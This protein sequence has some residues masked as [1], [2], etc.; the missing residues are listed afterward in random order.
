MKCKIL[1]CSTLIGA[2]VLLATEGENVLED[3]N[4][5]EEVS[6]PDTLKIIE[7]SVVNNNETSIINNSEAS[8]NQWEEGVKKNTEGFTIIKAE[9]I[10]FMLGVAK[11]QDPW[12]LGLRHCAALQNWLLE[13]RINNSTY[14]TFPL[15]IDL[16]LTNKKLAK[17]AILVKEGNRFRVA[18]TPKQLQEFL[19]NNV[20]TN[21]EIRSE[22]LGF[23]VLHETGLRDKIN[24]SL[25]NNRPV[26][27][28][29]AQNEDKMV[30]DFYT[31]IGA[32]DDKFLMLASS[33]N[34]AGRIKAMTAKELLT[35]MNTKSISTQVKKF[36]AYRK[37]IVG[38][39]STIAPLTVLKA[40]K[41]Y[42]MVVIVDNVLPVIKTNK[43][44]NNKSS[45]CTVS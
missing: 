39:G 10:L 2:S 35:A 4:K 14:E 34:G 15:S 38:A 9:S 16:D 36:D 1:L 19:N 45:N 32:N 30:V 43:P 44:K 27:V 13:T 21:G 40:W 11:Q 6:N 31:I 20:F 8:D 25:K 5:T 28:Y 12:M 17:L 3:N 24:S 18:P 41:P 33:G 42:S 22:A 26:I 29:Y 23:D 37:K 7:N